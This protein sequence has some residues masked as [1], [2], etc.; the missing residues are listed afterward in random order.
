MYSS[1]SIGYTNV[2][3]I[4]KNNTVISLDDIMTETDADG[5][6]LESKIDDTTLESLKGPDGKYY[7]L[8]HYEWFPGVTYDTT[9]RKFFDELYK[10]H[11]TEKA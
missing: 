8:P 2:Y 9:K 1:L 7:A 11:Y 5:K 3:S 4:A 10:A 6:T